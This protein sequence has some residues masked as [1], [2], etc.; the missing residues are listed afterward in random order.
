MLA[1][2]VGLFFISSAYFFN[3]WIDGISFPGFVVSYY[4]G[5][6]IAAIGLIICIVS[7]I[8]VRDEIRLSKAVLTAI[9]FLMLLS[10]FLPLYYFSSK[11]DKSTA[12][13][14]RNVCHVFVGAAFV[15]LGFLPK[16][17]II[18]NGCVFKA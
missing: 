3:G 11:S 10:C 15:I 9:L 6:L 2:S 7:K 17:T 14:I 12:T 4:P 16:K 18:E 8:E 5:T 13:V 1:S